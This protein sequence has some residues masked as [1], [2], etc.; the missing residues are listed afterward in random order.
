MD[1]RLSPA[2]QRR[3]GMR[4]THKY[5]IVPRAQARRQTL[6]ATPDEFADTMD[7]RRTAFRTR[8]EFLQRAAVEWV[9]EL[10]EVFAELLVRG[11]SVLSLGSGQGEHD[12]PLRLAGYDVTASDIVPSALEPARRLF[13]D[14]PTRHFD[15]FQPDTSRRYDD[16]LITGLDYCLDQPRA[17]QLF[18]NC[19]A[20]LTPGGRLIFTLRH[21]ETPISWAIDTM[22]APSLALA[23]LAK[24]RWRG[25]RDLAV[26]RKPHG[27]R[28]SRADILRLAAAAGF[29][30]GRVRVAG[31][32]GELFRLGVDH[33]F[34]RLYRALCRLDRRLHAL[35]M[36]T[37]FEFLT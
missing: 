27:Y 18:T 3:P 7:Y 28:R 5:L 30:P 13:P 17:Q 2:G 15:I 24:A 9:R 8:E 35:A 34:P 10:H 31:W 37:V 1:R 26:Y 29:R 4:A 22:L 36:A 16:L 11:R 6:D 19:R 20:L 12:V 21:P 25:A 32:G 14:L 33:T 23:R